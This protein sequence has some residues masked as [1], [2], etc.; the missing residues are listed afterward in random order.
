MGD[1][2][3]HLESPTDAGAVRFSSLLAM[4][5]LVQVVQSHTA[6]HQLDVVRSD[7]MV[8][9]VNVPSPVLSDHSTIAW[10]WVYTAPINTT[11]VFIRVARGGRFAVMTVSAIFSNRTSYGVRLMMSLI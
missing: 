9:S 6:G 2:Y 7:S 1:V 10:R 5:N 3:L 11:R 8:T 4:N